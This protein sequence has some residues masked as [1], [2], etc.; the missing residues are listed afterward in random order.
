MI[1]FWIPWGWEWKRASLQ[2]VRLFITCQHESY[3]LWEQGSA[4]W[5]CKDGAPD[6]SAS[7]GILKRHQHLQGQVLSC[8]RKDTCWKATALSLCLTNVF[9]ETSHVTF[10][11]LTTRWNILL[12]SLKPWR[13]SSPNWSH[14]LKPPMLR[15]KSLSCYVPYTI[16]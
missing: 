10:P 7:T 11:S 16:F 14:C 9:L 5:L 8:S 12:F 1:S 4:K 6:S 13:D 3:S 2:T 15:G